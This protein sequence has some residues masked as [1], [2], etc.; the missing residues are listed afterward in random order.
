MNPAGRPG[1]RMAK[2]LAVVAFMM[3]VVWIAGESLRNRGTAEQ[4]RR[5]TGMTRDDLM[6]ASAQFQKDHAVTRSVFAG[7]TDVESNLRDL[8]LYYSRRAFAGAP[9]EIP[10]RVNPGEF[11]A[12]DCNICHEKGG[13][14]AEFNAYSPLTPHPNYENCMQCHV[15]VEEVRLF[16]ESD[17]V[18]TEPPK[19]DRAALP[20][21]PPPIP[22]TLQLRENCVSCHA[23][24]AAPLAI[25]TRHPERENCIQ[26]HVPQQ[27][28]SYFARSTSMAR[29]PRGP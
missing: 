20:G 29:N 16:A 7:P 25:R 14:V 8:S 18:S 1:R 11:F 17:W 23:G 6:H 22:H 5:R 9:P 24:P 4:A 12:R 27:T 3:V 19:L 28:D 10:H 2:L 21:G 13:F 15:A 26:C